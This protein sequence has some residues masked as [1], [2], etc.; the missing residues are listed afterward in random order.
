MSNQSETTITDALYAEIDHGLDDDNYLHY[1]KKLRELCRLFEEKL[2]REQKRNEE[3]KAHAL[4]HLDTI[5]LSEMD[6]NEKHLAELLQRHGESH[7]PVR[8]VYPGSL[9]AWQLTIRR[10]RIERDRALAKVHELEKSQNHG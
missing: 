6:P 7:S 5:A 3:L 1:L 4:K 9:M 2:G 8:G 10:L